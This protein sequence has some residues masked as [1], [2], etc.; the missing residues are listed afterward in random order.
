M[1]ENI[2]TPEEELSSLLEEDHPPTSKETNNQDNELRIGGWL[3]KRRKE[4]QLDEVV[5]KHHKKPRI[6]TPEDDQ[7]AP[8]VEHQDPGMPRTASSQDTHL[9]REEVSIH[10]KDHDQAHQTPSSLEEENCH[11]EERENANGPIV[12]GGE[13]SNIVTSCKRAKE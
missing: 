3:R 7:D 11:L 13:E 1:E 10:E 4:I 8:G 5:D 6:E 12:P 9:R 2:Q